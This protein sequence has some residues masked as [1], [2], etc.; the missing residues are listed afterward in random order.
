MTRSVMA[1]VIMR[2][3]SDIKVAHKLAELIALRAGL[4]P[5]CIPLFPGDKQGSAGQA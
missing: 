4:I 3:V 5:C 2:G 1:T